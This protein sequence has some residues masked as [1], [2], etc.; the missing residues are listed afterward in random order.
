MGRA[1]SRRAAS[2]TKGTVWTLPRVTRDWPWSS[3]HGFVTMGEYTPDRGADDPVPGYDDPAVGR[4]SG[5]RLW[6]GSPLDNSRL[7]PTDSRKKHVR[8]REPCLE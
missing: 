3:F 4:I 1:A 7:D 2:P 6:W 5:S 8:G